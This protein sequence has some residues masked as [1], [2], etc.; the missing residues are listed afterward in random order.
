M[1]DQYDFLSSQMKDILAPDVSSA[2]VIS[3]PYL[4]FLVGMKLDLI[5]VLTL[6][7]RVKVRLNLLT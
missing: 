5:H 4:V 7:L 6:L 3:V 1:L 2:T